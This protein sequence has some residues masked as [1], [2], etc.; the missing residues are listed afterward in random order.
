MQHRCRGGRGWLAKHA[1]APIESLSFPRLGGA[2]DRRIF[3][4]RIR[5]FG[6]RSDDAARRPGEPSEKVPAAGPGSCRGEPLAYC[7]DGFAGD[8]DGY[9]AYIDVFKILSIGSLLFVVLIFFLT[10]IDLSHP[11]QGGG[12]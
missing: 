3:A 2:Y 12:H 6:G 9:I 5:R 1:S 7:R 10:K 8:V 4:D 11:P